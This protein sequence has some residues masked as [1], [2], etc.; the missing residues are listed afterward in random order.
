MKQH[1]RPDIDYKKCNAYSGLAH[2]Y[3]AISVENSPVYATNIDSAN[4]REI[5]DDMKGGIIIFPQGVEAV[6]SEIKKIAKKQEPA[7]WTIG[8]FFKGRHTAKNEKVYSED[9]LSVEIIGLSDDALIETGE[10]FCREFKQKSV[11]IKAYSEKN[12]IF[13]VSGVSQMYRNVYI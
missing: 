5:P 1:I 7:G 8:K 4:K 10:Y 3:A 9:S 6:L 12:Q 13:L 11:L 2:M